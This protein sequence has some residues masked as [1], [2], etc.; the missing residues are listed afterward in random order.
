MSRPLVQSTVQVRIVEGHFL[1]EDEALEWPTI[2]TFRGPGD[3]LLT[4]DD[5][6]AVCGASGEWHVVEALLQRWDIT[7]STLDPGWDLHRQ[8]RCHFSSGRLNTWNPAREEIF[9]TFDLEAPGTYDVRVHTTD[10]DRTRRALEDAATTAGD[11]PI[12][13]IERFLIQFRPAPEQSGDRIAT[14]TE[15][16][17]PEWQN[18]IAALE[19]IADER[20]NRAH[21]A[22]SRRRR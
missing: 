15:T 8:G 11:Q 20:R 14:A 9:G 3:W 10:R 7:P 21:D 12:R 19:M 18:G 4:T 13:G 17:T 22:R 5:Q 1:I 6:I 2:P 16:A